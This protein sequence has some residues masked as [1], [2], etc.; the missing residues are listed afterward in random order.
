MY[1][2]VLAA[3]FML[4]LLSSWLVT[5]L[6]YFYNLLGLIFYCFANYFCIVGQIVVRDL[7]I[8]LLIKFEACFLPFLVK[9]FSGY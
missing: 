3:T 9:Q 5:K 4:K 7:L 1:A 8:S 6:H 2:S